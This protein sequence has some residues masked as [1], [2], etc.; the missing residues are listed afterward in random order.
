MVAGNR[1]IESHS[2]DG[3][4]LLLFRKL[5]DRRLRYEGEWVCQGVQE[6]Q[7]PDREGNLRRAAREAPRT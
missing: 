3:E 5:R 4:S 6:R 2:R 1:A 7:A